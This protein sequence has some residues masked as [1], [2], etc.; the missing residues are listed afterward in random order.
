[1][2]L[3]GGVL[4]W[5]VLFLVVLLFGLDCDVLFGVCFVV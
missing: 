1:M 2:G 3:G 5:V 4:F